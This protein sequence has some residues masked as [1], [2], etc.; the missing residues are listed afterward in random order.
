M[1]N[2][3]TAVQQVQ[4]I[5][6]VLAMRVTLHASIAKA[7]AEVEVM[8]NVPSAPP[9]VSTTLSADN[10]VVA[11]VLALASLHKLQSYLTLFSLITQTQQ[12]QSLSCGHSDQSFA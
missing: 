2:K 3:R 10:V 9:Y 12:M 11:V 7:A 6:R 8:F 4:P 1:S 5:A